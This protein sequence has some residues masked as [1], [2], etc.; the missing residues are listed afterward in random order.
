VAKGSWTVCVPLARPCSDSDGEV[1]YSLTVTLT[2]FRLQVKGGKKLFNLVKEAAK[3][4]SQEMGAPVIKSKSN[5]A[6]EPRE[7]YNGSDKRIEKER[8]FV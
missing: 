8:M 4:I 3:A 2:P 7:I 6:R 5:S 1:H